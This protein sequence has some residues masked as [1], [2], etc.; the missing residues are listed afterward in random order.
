M[1]RAGSELRTFTGQPAIQTMPPHT[2][3]PLILIERYAYKVQ[4]CPSGHLEWGLFRGAITS[5]AT[6]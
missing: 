5:T 2:V 1:I 4:L 3:I 6:H